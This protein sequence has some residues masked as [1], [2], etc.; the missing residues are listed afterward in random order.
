MNKFKLI[1]VTFSLVFSQIASA[2]TVDEIIDGSF[3]ATGGKEAWSK[4][5]GIKFIAEGSQGPMKFPIE[6]VQ[7]ADGRTYMQFSIQGK[8]LR[9]NVFDGE[10][11]W[12]TNMMT[13]KAEKQSAETIENTK[14]DANDFPSSLFNY[15]AKGYTAELVGKEELDGSEVYKVRLTKE[16]ISVDGKKVD[17]VEYHYFDVDSLVELATETEVHQGPGKGTIMMTKFS[18]YDEVNGLYFPFSLAQSAKGGQQFFTLQFKTIELNPK[19]DAAE[20]SL[21]KE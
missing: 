1:L 15:K 14:L 12:S 4:L 5:K 13:M 11:V 18:D 20:F 10:T 2:I 6:M 17:S 3:E 7:L 9:Q 16:P 21:P 19:V 8:Q